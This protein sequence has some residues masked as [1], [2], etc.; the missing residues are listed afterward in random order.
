[1]AREKERERERER[2]LTIYYSFIIFSNKEPKSLLQVATK[3]NMA[4]TPATD[5]TRELATCYEEVTR[6]LLP[7]NL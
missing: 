2:E 4:L 6:K 3:Y 7:W 5:V 1:M